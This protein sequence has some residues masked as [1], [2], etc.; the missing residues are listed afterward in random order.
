MARLIDA[1]A[2]GM[3]LADVKFGES[4]AIIDPPDVRDIKRAQCIGLG[5]AI[6]AIEDAPTV[7]DT[8]LTEQEEKILKAFRERLAKA[9]ENE[10]IAN[11]AAWAL[12]WTW[13]DLDMHRL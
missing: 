3:Y 4:P 5:M 1:D 12:Y 13:R 10:H 11:P 2:L 8:G 7:M 9:H 6:Q